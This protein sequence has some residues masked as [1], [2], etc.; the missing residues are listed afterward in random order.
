VRP[1][2]EYGTP[3]WYPHHTGLN[4][5]LENAQRK[6]T[7]RINGPSCLSHGDRLVYLK[8]DSLYVLGISDK[9]IMITCYQIINGLVAINC[10]D[11][12]SLN[13]V[14]TRGHNFK[15][16]MSEADLARVSL[17]LC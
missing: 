14:R 13:D 8:L 10:S 12:F 7:K 11:H 4:Y 1:T 16:Y 15:L 6:C 9:I 3:V 2:L 17:Q 5:K